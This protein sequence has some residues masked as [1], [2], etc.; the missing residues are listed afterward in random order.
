MLVKTLLI[1]GASVAITGCNSF[2][3]QDEVAAT[4]TSFWTI[5]RVLVSSTPPHTRRVLRSRLLSAYADRVLIG[6]CNPMV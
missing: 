1:G 6:A 3:T 2:S 4:S 5:S